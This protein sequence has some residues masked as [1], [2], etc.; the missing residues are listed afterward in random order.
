MIS[1][2]TVFFLPKEHHLVFIWL[3]VYWGQIPSYHF[4]LPENVFI[5][6]YFEWH[7]CWFLFWVEKCLL[8]IF[9]RWYFIIFRLPYFL[10]HNQ[11]LKYSYSFKTTCHFSPSGCS[12]NSLPAIFVWCIYEWFSLPLSRSLPLSLLTFGF[13]EVLEFVVCCL[14]FC[15][16]NFSVIHISSNTVS[17]LSSLLSLPGTPVIF[18]KFYHSSLPL[19]CC[20]NTFSINLSSSYLL[21]LICKFFNVIL[22]SDGFQF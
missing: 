4:F 16:G 1:S 9:K 20:F 22:I 8:L 14:L 6:L 19:F 3:W 15:L 10:L 13:A 5:C 11:L 12:Y 17:F 18:S 2:R 7:F 21:T